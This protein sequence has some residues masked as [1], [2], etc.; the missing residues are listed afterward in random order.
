MTQAEITT[1]SNLYKTKLIDC[2][3]HIDGYDQSINSF[4]KFKNYLEKSNEKAQK[5]KILSLF[6]SC[7]FGALAI[8]TIFSC[9]PVGLAF[10]FASLVSLE[11]LAFFAKVTRK[12]N[13]CITY[14]TRVIT[15]LSTKQSDYMLQKEYALS[16]IIKLEKTIP[17]TISSY[18]ENNRNSIIE[19]DLEV[20]GL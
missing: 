18:L 5:M 3:N 20:C 17:E 6:F 12:F 11:R 14:L 9:L 1:K 13:H 7:T 10:I 2:E 4:Q 8:A 19:E 16:E 15:N